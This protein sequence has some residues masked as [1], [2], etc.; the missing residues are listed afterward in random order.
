MASALRKSPLRAAIGIALLLAGVAA[1]LLLSSPG[2]DPGSSS[3]TTANS[4]GAGPF[5]KSESASSP[6]P[7]LTRNLSAGLTNHQ[8][9][10][11]RIVAGF[12]GTT[13]PPVIRR[14]IKAGLI[15]GVILFADNLGSDA[16]IR[17]LT[18]AL[19]R[20][21]RP[22]G[23]RRYPLM[24]MVDQEGGLVKRLPGA[25]NASA[26]QMGRR[27]PAFSRRQGALAGLNLKT[28][29]FNVDLAP[30]LDV[31]RPG[32]VIADTDRGFGSTVKKVKAT[33]IP[34]ARALQQTRVAA[35]AKHFPGLGAAR[36]N[37]D[38]A[39]QKIRLTRAALRRVDMA[40]YEP[41]IAARGK[42]IMVGSAIYPALGRRPAMFEPKIVRGELR[43]RLGFQGVTITDAM[44]TV[45]VNDF[46]G[47]KRAA[48]SA[49]H[50]GMD[51][52][53]YGDWQSAGRAEQAIAVRLRTGKLPRGQFTRAVNRILQ[54]R[55]SLAD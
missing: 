14:R 38:F 53:L 52:L 41:F 12:E 33:A 45:A 9:A 15:G 24:I 7:P 23:L 3:G 16:R 17:H 55:S 8:M 42:L 31:A 4:A 39:V 21:R 49:A 54:L 32:G 19:Q 47:T 34:F 10:G 29:G 51:I 28:S 20:I 27:G 46:G 13:V 18:R 50:A 36:Q 44:G 30:V 2:G 26:E 25:P 11:Q 40:P 5:V 6:F 35:T 37:T 1:L 22:D 43:Q 48:I